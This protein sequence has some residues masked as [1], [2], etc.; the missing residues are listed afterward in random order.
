MERLADVSSRRQLFRAVLAGAAALPL[1]ACNFGDPDSSGTNTA[2][3]GDCSCKVSCLL[4]CTRVSTPSGE[5]PVEDLQIGDEILTLSGPRAVKWV[6]YNKYTKDADRS[7]Q[8]HVIPIRIAPSAFADQVPQ[9]DLYL[10]PEHR[11]FVN[12]VLIAVKHL[13]NGTSIAPAQAGMA[14]I[15]YYHIEFDTHEVIL[16][17]ARRSRASWM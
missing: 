4:N 7:W 8:S 11:V 6:G 9:C 12:E 10:S 14:T 15:E 16:P 2:S 13:V 1:A 5:R 17:K 3:D